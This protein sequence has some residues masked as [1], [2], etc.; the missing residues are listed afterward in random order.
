[1]DAF[2][3][4]SLLC[5]RS[6]IQVKH[7]YSSFKCTVLYKHLGFLRKINVRLR[8][9]CRSRVLYNTWSTYYIFECIKASSLEY[10]I[11]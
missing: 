8:N 4:L 10:N 3:N 7:L 9:L 5:P 2:L 6:E 11:L 1:M